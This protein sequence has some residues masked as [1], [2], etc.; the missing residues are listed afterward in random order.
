[1][2]IKTIKE[3]IKIY[4]H[5]SKREW[6]TNAYNIPVTHF[7]LDKEGAHK[8]NEILKFVVSLELPTIFR[9]KSGG[10]SN[11]RDFNKY[12]CYDYRW[13]STCAEITLL[14]LDGCWRFQCR[15]KVPENKKG[16]SMY[17]STCLKEFKKICLMFGIDLDDYAVDNGLEIKAEWKSKEKRIYKKQIYGKSL[18][19]IDETLENV[20][21]IDLCSGFQ[22]GLVRAFPE[23]KKPCQ[24]LYDLR[25]TDEAI[26]L[27]Q[28]ESIGA[29][30]SDQ[31][32][33][34]YIKLAKGAIEE[35]NRL[36]MDIVHRLVASGRQ[37]LL[38]N[39]DGVWYQGDVYH[40]ETEFANLGGWKND[41]KNCKFRMKNNVTYE[42]IEDG[43]Y[44]VVMSGQTTLDQVKCR[45]D[46]EWGDIYKTSVIEYKIDK[47]GISTVKGDYL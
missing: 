22:S 6:K 26:K 29:M 15:T 41:H 7:N 2:E 14:T 36:L 30:W 31:R 13:T 35:N 40:D 5:F 32:Q 28:V 11:Y 9:T 46:W 8:F 18:N 3:L 17:G 25:K 12:N 47:N 42:F 10:V 45:D 23:F 16:K 39:T 34:K 44:K 43:K 33:A 20:H 4:P 24:Y 21:H 19:L 1:M 37:P 27:I 38:L